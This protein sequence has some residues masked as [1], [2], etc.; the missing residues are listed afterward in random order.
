VLLFG[1]AGYGEASTET[2]AWALADLWLYNASAAGAGAGAGGGGLW[3][4]F[5]GSKVAKAPASYTA[6]ARW[7][8]A[9]A[10]HAAWA[11]GAGGMCLFGGS[12][13]AGAA[14]AA[15]GLLN[16]VWCWAAGAS[17][18]VLHGGSQQTGALAN[19]G[20]AMSHQACA[21]VSRADLLD[22]G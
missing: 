4:H 6:G 10:D 2:A 17:E 9:R 5:G 15:R 20:G 18:W 8:G 11:E 1:G 13:Y 14:G 12:G 16:D 21:T 22:R 19:Y 3:T 7:P